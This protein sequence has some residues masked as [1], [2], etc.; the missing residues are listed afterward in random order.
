MAGLPVRGMALVTGAAQGVGRAVA[1][2]LS[3]S[4]FTVAAND[5]APSELLSSLV[6]DIGGVPSI[7]DV[8]DADAVRQMVRHLEA[9]AGAVELLVSNAAYMSMGTLAE[10]DPADW[11]RHIDVNLSGTFNA[12]SAVI[13]GMLQRGRGR[14][15]IL[16]SRWGVTG[17][18]GASAYAASKAGLISFAK[19][20][21]REL[22]PSGIQV[23]VVA[24]GP[25]DTAQL[26]N[27][28]SAAGFTLEAFKETAAASIPARRVLSPEEVAETVAFLAGNGAEA[29]VGQVLQPNGGATTC[30]F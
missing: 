24:P 9:S 27:D 14:I 6:R 20:L 29:I 18:A 4:G 1:V 26:S 11:W 16:S 17:Q 15:V 28:A 13:P 19:S 22:A 23:N 21:A 25:V 2:R 10:Q 7:A 8:S 3:R 5:K 12:V 30:S